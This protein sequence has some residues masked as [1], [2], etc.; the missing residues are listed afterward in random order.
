VGPGTLLDTDKHVFTFGAGFTFVYEPPA[1][2][3]ATKPPTTTQVTQP[4]P[5]APQRP[6]PFRGATIDIDVFFQYHHLVDRS[7]NRVD[8]TDPLGPVSFGG[9]I[10]NLGFGIGARF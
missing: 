4:A 5:T 6:S 2:P 3:A 8:P 9:G 10:W 7:A 1:E